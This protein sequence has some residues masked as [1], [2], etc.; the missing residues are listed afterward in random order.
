MTFAMPIVAMG[1]SV[2]LLRLAGL[3]LPERAI[4]TRWE[5]ALRS[6]PVA[7]L[8]ALVVS[9]LSGQAAVEPIRLIAAA[10]A[11]LLARWSGRMWA[12]ILGGMAAFYVLRLL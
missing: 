9:S 1:A 10:A 6:V 11:A 5:R 2:Y 8:T 4:P 12:C 7:L 3:L